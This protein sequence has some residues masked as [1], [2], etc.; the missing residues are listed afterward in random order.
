MLSRRIARASPFRLATALPARPLP[1][2]QLR[3]YIPDSMTGQGGVL[4]RKYPKSDY[5]GLSEAQDPEMNGGYVNPPRIKRQFRDPHGDW[6]DKQERRNYGEPVHEDHDMMGMFTPYEYTWVKPGKGLLQIGAFITAVFTLAYGISLVYP[7]RRSYPREFEGGLVKELG[8]AGAPRRALLSNLPNTSTAFPGTRPSTMRYEDWDVILFPAGRDSKVPF[9]EFK[10]GCHVVPDVELSHIYGSMGMPVMT[11][12]VPSLAAGAPFQISIHSWKNPEISQFTRTYSKHADLVKFEARI[13]LDGRMVA[14]TA[15]DRKVNG[16]HLI[17]STFE[18]TKTGELER[19]KFPYFRRELLF[20]SHWNPG[21]DIGRIKIVISEGFPR[22]S[23]SVP[24]ERVKN[25]VTFSFQHAPLE[26]LES[27]GIAWPNPTMWR[28][29]PYAPSMPVP[30]FHPADGP[31]SHAHSPRRRSLLLRNSKSQGFPAPMVTGNIFEPAPQA[32]TGFGGNPVLQ[33]PYLPRNNT[34]SGSSLSYPDPFT[35][36]AAYMEWINSVTN[37]Q[38]SDSVGGKTPWPVNMRSSR[39]QSSS[40]TNMPDFVHSHV[41]DPMHISGP[42]L[43]DDPMSLKVPTNTPT[44]GPLDEHQSVQY[45]VCSHSMGL[46]PDL[47]TSLTHSLLNQPFPLPIQPHNIPLPSSEVKSRKENRQLAVG[48]SNALSGLSTPHIDHVE[49]R[50]F[51]QSG[52]NLGSVESGH[53]LA[54]PSE[55][56]EC[57]SPANLQSATRTN[58]VSR[59]GT[60]A[61]FGSNITNFSAGPLNNMGDTTGNTLN[62]GFGSNSNN[63]N[64]SGSGMKRTRTFTPVSAK[65]IDEED[66]PR[67]ASPHVRIAGFGADMINDA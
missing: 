42:S 2:I 65:V 52:F 22:D 31:D 49:D 15:F 29:P 40:D 10:V 67:R 25:V 32:T 51:S 61:D 3:T 36:S 16:P 11:C 62:L 54:G 20:Q 44:A 53:V 30:T 27:T 58:S 7:D 5:A 66:E 19:L 48:E 33:V 21:D 18:F 55:N 64:T 14:S 9:K 38:S 24:I 4:E 23:L 39:K 47:A 37:A 45:P 6:W 50:K 35:E 63:N 46:P 60:A 56:A 26:T 34:G 57:A 28:R 41:G 8:G 43:E 17:T 59:N 13:M 1:A 12:F